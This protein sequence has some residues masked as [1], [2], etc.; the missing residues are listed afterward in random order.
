MSMYF[1]QFANYVARAS[2]HPLVFGTA[3]ISLVLW[4]LSGPFFSF[5]DTWQLVMNTWTNVITFLMVFLIQN[6]Q[7]R[8]GS[9]LQVKLDELIRVSAASNSF[10]AVE[11]LS[12]EQIE[13]LRKRLEALAPRKPAE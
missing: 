2:G 10:M 5:S 12:P 3:A 9:A 8:E 4:L 6:S 11:E 13:K 7:N 1:A